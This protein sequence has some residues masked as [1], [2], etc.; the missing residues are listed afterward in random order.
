MEPPSH[1]KDT[2]QCIHIRHQYGHAKNYCNRNPTCVRCAEKYL[3]INY[4]NIG[5]INEIKCFN[6]NGNHPAGYKGCVV[7]KQ[8]QRK[9]FLPLRNRTYINIQVQQN[10]TKSETIPNTEH[11]INIK[12][13]STNTFGSRSYARVIS[14][15]PPLDNQNQNNMSND[16]TKIKELLKQ[17]IKNTE[18]LTKMLSELNAVLRQ[19]TQQIT[20]MLQ[21]L[22]N[23][24]SKK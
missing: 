12:H 24:L 14:Q 5:T 1:K 4:P 9:L 16:T 15:L 11:A 17:S 2:L 6:C 22:T 23:V 21:L 3:T 7:R 8:L 13:I 20:V 18:M 10:S 19:Q